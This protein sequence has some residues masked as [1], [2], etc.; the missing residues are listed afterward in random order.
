MY[1]RSTRAH[2]VYVICMPT[3]LYACLCH[4]MHL[5]R[6]LIVTYKLGLLRHNTHLR[7]IVHNG[8]DVIGHDVDGEVF[9]EL[10]HIRAD[11]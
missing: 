6:V 3:S 4:Y 7:S 8:A 2:D 10:A 11:V 5:Y 1:Q 9:V